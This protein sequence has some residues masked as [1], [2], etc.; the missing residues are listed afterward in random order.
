MAYLRLDRGTRV[1]DIVRLPRTQKNVLEKILYCAENDLLAP[2]FEEL[3]V[4]LEQKSKI[5][6]RRAVMELKAKG[7]VSLVIRNKRVVSRSV[8]PTQG[9]WDWWK[10]QGDE[11][12]SSQAVTEEG[13]ITAS[14]EADIAAAGDDQVKDPLLIG[15][16]AAGQPTL[17]EQDASDNISLNSLFRGRYL[18]MLKV[19]GDS[20]IGDHIVKG[21]YVIVDSDAECKDGEMVVIFVNGEA[22][23]KRLWRQDDTFRLVSSNPL[24]EP[25]TV[26]RDDESILQGKVIG[27]VRDQ[28][29][30]RYSTTPDRDPTDQERPVRRKSKS[31][32][33]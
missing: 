22:T 18:S 25:I 7:L 23:V 8:R 6:A 3:A 4:M 1:T 13:N 24:Q 21:D 28:I 11:T 27:V 10:S 19:T 2:T 32:G 31:P 29:K 9:A 14:G 16:V 33:N 30:R 20:M 17:A 5:N 26:K 15:Q 12:R